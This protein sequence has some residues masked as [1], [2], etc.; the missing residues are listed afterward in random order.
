MVL[1]AWSNQTG[2]V[3]PNINA[4]FYTG[5]FTGLVVPNRSEL[6]IWELVNADLSPLT[7]VLT[8]RTV[9]WVSWSAVF[10]ITVP[11]GQNPQQFNGNPTREKLGIVAVSN[12]IYHCR[13]EVLN[14]RLQ[15]VQRG[16]FYWANGSL[17]P[18]TSILALPP[19]AQSFD[20]F[21]TPSA[22]TF[23]A[24]NAD[25]EW[26]SLTRIAW[27]VLPPYIAGMRLTYSAVGI[28]G[29]FIDSSSSL[30]LNNI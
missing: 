12:G 28:S 29:N 15:S 24:A 8:A 9:Y 19:P 30:L 11:P 1:T 17:E 20:W 13:D 7:P 26:R 21:I 10:A 14:Y 18:S 25:P 16:G 27:D 22:L 2:T 23:Q 3:T 5:A 4:L 6:N